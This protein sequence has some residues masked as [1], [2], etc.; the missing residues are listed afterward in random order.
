MNKNGRIKEIHDKF[1]K[2]KDFISLAQQSDILD[3]ALSDSEQINADYIKA[4][5][6]ILYSLKEYVT[7]TNLS[8]NQLPQDV[9]F[10]NLSEE[11]QSMLFYLACKSI[12][13]DIEENGEI[14]LTRYISVSYWN[15]DPVFFPVFLRDEKNNKSNILRNKIVEAITDYFSDNNIK[16]ISVKVLEPLDSQQFKSI[17]AAN[18][19]SILNWFS[20]TPDELY[21]QAK[22]AAEDNREWLQT[23]I[24]P[25]SV[26]SKNYI[27][28][29]NQED[30]FTI[31]DLKD[32]LL[33][34]ELNLR[35]SIN[36]VLSFEDII[37]KSEDGRFYFWLSTQLDIP[38]DTKGNGPDSREGFIHCI[39]D[40]NNQINHMHVSIDFMK[41][42]ECLETV[43]A[44]KE[45]FQQNEI[46]SLTANW[47]SKATLADSFTFTFGTIEELGDEYFLNNYNSFIYIPKNATLN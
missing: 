42:G 14:S 34:D 35:C 41:N 39:S 28:I 9:L 46:L 37:E 2:I 32:Y 22:F 4:E 47:S 21:N 45:V 7:E 20:T 3:E 33:K 40:E 36:D 23:V 31:V 10:A 17:M 11:D 16:D 19:L 6:E 30:V 8:F 43:K 27:D 5:L 44:T 29:C 1:L 15:D 13:I 25:I 38:L 26:R 18:P 12:S 24:I